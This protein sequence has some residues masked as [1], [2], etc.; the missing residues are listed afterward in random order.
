MSG[1]KDTNWRSYTGISPDTSGFANPP[2]PQ[3]YDDIFKF[4]N[5]ENVIAC[6]LEIAAG[7]ENNVD[8][9]R[10]SCYT[11]AY[12]NLLSGAG[13]ATMTIKGSINNLKIANCTIGRSNGS[14]EIELGQFDKYWYP[15]RLPTRNIVIE[16]CESSD[17][18]PIRIDLWDADSPSVF[19][20]TVRIRRIPKLVWFPYFCVRWLWI[21]IFD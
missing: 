8:A 20:S 18:K 4:S 10:G 14:C 19:M 6:K 16:S 12:L 2:D 1:T 3:N 15:G 11:F 9:V 7:R 5:C 17:G 21:R 13:V